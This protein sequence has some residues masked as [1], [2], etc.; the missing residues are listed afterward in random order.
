[1]QTQWLTQLCYICISRCIFLPLRSKTV[2]FL[3][4]GIS[5]KVAEDICTCRSRR[6]LVGDRMLLLNCP[7]IICALVETSWDQFQHSVMSTADTCRLL[8]R[9]HFGLL[10]C[11]EWDKWHSGGSLPSFSLYFSVFPSL[12]KF[13]FLHAGR[14]QLYSWPFVLFGDLHSPM[15]R[16]HYSFAL[17]WLLGFWSRASFQI[18]LSS[19]LT[20]NN[21]SVHLVLFN[22]NAA[23]WFTVTCD[24]STFAIASR[25]GLHLKAPKS[26]WQKNQTLKKVHYLL[27][28]E[29]NETSR[30]SW[31]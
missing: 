24:I 11:R 1:M 8:A 9:S 10:A 6:A 31:V 13:F 20:W 29:V 27:L 3:K 16:L 23:S 21:V 5:D 2:F 25:I 30:T 17:W 7:C 28:H 19:N 14:L 4:H 26:G 12:S 22:V 15:L 18:V